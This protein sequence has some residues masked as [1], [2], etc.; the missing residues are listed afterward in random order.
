MLRLPQNLHRSE[1]GQWRCEATDGCFHAFHY[2]TNAVVPSLSW[3]RVVFRAKEGGCRVFTRVASVAGMVEN[4]EDL[5]DY[6][7]A[8]GEGIRRT[9]LGFEGRNVVLYRT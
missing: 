2:S 6:L 8:R 1:D 5:L 4:Y 9:T 3:Q 7:Q